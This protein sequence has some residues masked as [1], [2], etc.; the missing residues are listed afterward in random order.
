LLALGSPIGAL[1]G[2]SGLYLSYYLNL[3]SG[4][5]IVLLSTL[6]FVVCFVC[7][8]SDGWLAARLRRWRRQ[9]A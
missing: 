5:T 7:A 3:A 6:V 2:V 1:C 4:G 8:P 9:R